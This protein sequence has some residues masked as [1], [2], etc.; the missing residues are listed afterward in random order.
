MAKASPFKPFDDPSV[1]AVFDAY[2]KPVRDKLLALRSLIVEAAAATP[3]VG[4]IEETLK[5]G[6]PSYLTPQTKSGTT[7]R[8][9]AMKGTPNRYAL[10]VHCQTKL[11]DAFREVYP[12]ELT[13][14]GNRA[15]LFDVE[16]PLPV[17]PVRHCI[18][19]ALTYHLRKK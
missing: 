10:Y 17:E 11:I 3:G 2:P 19:Q 1:A 8:I 7:V 5:W 9:D 16:E 15:I 4:P 18:A 6:Q 14:E 12:D 13:Y